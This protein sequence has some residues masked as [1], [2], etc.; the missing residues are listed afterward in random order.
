MNCVLFAKMDQV[1]SLKINQN[2]KTK[3]ENGKNYLKSQGILSV[4][5]NGNHVYVT[6][7][8]HFSL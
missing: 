2:I 3:L 4:R 7:T 5:K 1:F 8:R 6:W